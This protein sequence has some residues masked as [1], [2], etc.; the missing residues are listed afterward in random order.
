MGQAYDHHTHHHAGAQHMTR[1]HVSATYRTPSGKVGHYSACRIASNAQAAL[2]WAQT[3][4]GRTRKVCGRLA[5]DICPM[6][7]QATR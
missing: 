6:I 4:I 5:F 1:F 2:E 7:D 3:E